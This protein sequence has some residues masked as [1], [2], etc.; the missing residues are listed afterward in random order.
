[1]ANNFDE[2]I[3]YLMNWLWKNTFGL[4]NS[5]PDCTENN[6]E[7]KR[8]NKESINFVTRFI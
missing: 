5:K 2:N 3:A 1:M 8:L 7:K 6:V 4:I